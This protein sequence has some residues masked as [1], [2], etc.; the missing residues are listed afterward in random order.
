V[1]EVAH[2][3]TNAAEAVSLAEFTQAETHRWRTVPRGT[4]VCDGVTFICNGAIR[5]AG[6]SAAREGN[7]YPGAVLGV[8]VNRRGSRLHL[9]QAAEN[10]TEMLE[11][12]PYGR[13]VVHYA[14]GESRRF[15]LLFGVHGDDWAQPKGAPND[16]VIDS[17]SGVAWLQR[18][19]GDGSTVR[20]YHT[21]LENP[22]PEISITTVDFISPLAEAN[23]LL[24][25]LAL[26][27]DPRPLAPS[28]GPGERIGDSPSE[29]ITFTLQDAAGQ[30]VTGATLSW[31][32]R[33]PR[34]QIDFPPFPADASGQVT[35]DVPR[36]FILGL[37]YEASA[38]D[39]SS[40]SGEL[41]LNA[42]GSWPLQPT[43]KLSL[44]VVPK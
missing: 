28:Y 14:D 32:V 26:N 16:P 35:I 40:A 18:R 8:P 44:T 6:L 41:K 11:G 15:D 38:P 30:P 2:R 39:G 43:L 34:I 33:G 42:D 31:T 13:M 9:L 29:P 3:A 20:I 22:L 4:Q 19:T 25:G 24:F 23:L 10:V 5:T 17:N 27:D 7:R 1:A 21:A 36:R 12:A 37:H